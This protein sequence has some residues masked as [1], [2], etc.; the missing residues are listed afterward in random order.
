MLKC[1]VTPEKVYSLKENEIFVFGSNLLG[2]H[3]RGAAKD[4]L[5]NYGAILG[6]GEGLQGQSY[7]L[8]TKNTPTEFMPYENLKQYIDRLHLTI[9]QNPNLH[10][11]ITKVGCNLAGF[12][13]WEI[14]PLFKDFIFLNNC[15]LPRDFLDFIFGNYE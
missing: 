3:K 5:D 7:A 10:F 11:L 4:A 1:Q 6:Q 2:I 13:V 12:T 8:P 15:S 9:K 14:A